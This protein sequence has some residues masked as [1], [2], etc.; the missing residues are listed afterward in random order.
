MS[1]ILNDSCRCSGTFW[2]IVFFLKGSLHRRWHCRGERFVSG[3]G[4]VVRNGR[5]RGRNGTTWR[6]RGRHLPGRIC[7]GGPRR[8]RQIPGQD[9][10]LLRW[11]SSHFLQST[12]DNNK[13]IDYSSFTNLPLN[14]FTLIPSHS[15]GS[16]SGFSNSNRLLIPTASNQGRA[17][18]MR[19]NQ[20]EWKSTIRWINNQRPEMMMMM[21]NHL[22][23]RFDY[24]SA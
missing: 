23:N 10:S 11:I 16:F 2:K 7:S 3:A 21:V 9:P 1:S 20:L 18:R 24:G 5:I 8:R 22:K 4:A 12:L 17:A 15:M 13:T 14:W 6:R 19:I